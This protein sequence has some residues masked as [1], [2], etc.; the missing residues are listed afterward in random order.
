MAIRWSEG[1]APERDASLLSRLR[2]GLIFVAI[3]WS[4]AGAFLLLHIGLPEL[5]HR[6]LVAGWIPDELVLGDRARETPALHCGAAA[7]SPSP[8]RVD[9]ALAR[10]ARFASWKLGQHV[11]FAAG[12]ANL[13]RTPE[14][15]AALMPDIRALAAALGMAPPALPQIRH[16]GH[17]FAEFEAFVRSDADCVATNLASRYGPSHA[18]HYRFGLVVGYV[19]PVRVQGLGALF[20]AEIRHYGRLAGVP[21]SLWFPLTQDVLDATPGTTPKEKVLSVVEQL[22]RHIKGS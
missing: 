1:G 21:E 17:A 20:P 3:V 15:I 5:L 8:T 19:L 13:G 9:P 16:F 18:H 11:G 2:Q 4:I 14:E 22:D 12:M 7:G 10:E 6:L